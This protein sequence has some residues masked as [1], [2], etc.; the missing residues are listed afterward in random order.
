METLISK[1]IGWHPNFNGHVF[2]RHAEAMP[3]LSD[4]ISGLPAYQL[5]A[6][7]EAASKSCQSTGDN[8]ENP[9]TRSHSGSRPRKGLRPPLV[10][11]GRILRASFPPV[12]GGSLER[13]RT[14][15]LVMCNHGRRL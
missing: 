14:E 13:T 4:L 2:T 5:Q 11:L 15:K 6:M 1:N 3:Q 10:L 7:G 8:K 12:P 9:K